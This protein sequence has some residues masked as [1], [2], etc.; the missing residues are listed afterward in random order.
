M[1]RHDATRTPTRRA[2]KMPDN[3]CG[4]TNAVGDA[5]RTAIIYCSSQSG[6]WI[7]TFIATRC[8]DRTFEYLMAILVWPRRNGVAVAAML[9]QMLWCPRRRIDRRGTATSNRS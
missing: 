4:R 8:A 3:S 7:R 1:R 9:V 5:V 6:R 2:Q